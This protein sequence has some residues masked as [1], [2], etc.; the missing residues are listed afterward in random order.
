VTDDLE[1]LAASCLFPGFAGVTASDELRRWLERGLGGVVLFARNVRD[2]EQLRTLTAALRAERPDLIVAIDEEGGDVT[3]LEAASGSSYPGNHALGAVDD[4]ELTEQVAAALGSDLAGVGINLDLA[5][6]ADVNTNPRN[7]VIGVR[8][9]GA[10]AER[11][12]RHVAAFVSGMQRVGVAACAKHFPGHGATEQDSHHELPVASGNLEE[13]LLPFRA[14]VAA[15]VRAVMTAHIRVP[16][17]GERPATLNR[18]ILHGLLRGELGFS[19]LVITDA[20]EMRAVS[21]S[22]GVEEGAVLALAAGADALCLG[23]DLP[24]DAVHRALLAAVRTGRLDEGR[25]RETAERVSD[26][27]SWTVRPAPPDSR[28]SCDVGES[29][30]RRALQ[31]DGAVALSRPALVVELSP[32]PSMAAGEAGRGLGESLRSRLPATEVIRLA[33]APRDAARLLEG[34]ADR[35]LVIAVRDAHRHAWQRA[36]TESLVA[37]A[38]D[39][40]VVETGLPGWRPS[41][42]AAYLATHGAGRVNLDAAA[43]ALARD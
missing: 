17:L 35:Q 31:T 3:R 22:V 5:P 12:A 14:A 40:I 2:R 21:A 6:V 43:D 10:D 41:G 8:S 25:L 42:A 34:H 7:P 24:P 18:G 37:A 36:T 27:A 39:A 1:R 23:H 38:G 28:E 11:V 33:G 16:E 20:L 4:V 13:A 29:A 19:G 32:Q 26:T 9:F 15:E 30:A